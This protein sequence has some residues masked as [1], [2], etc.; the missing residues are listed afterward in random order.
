MNRCI[1]LLLFA[2][3][4]GTS[5]AG[6]EAQI[7]VEEPPHY[8]GEPVTVRIVVRGFEE[9]PQPT[10]EIAD[11]ASSGLR[12]QL[13]ALQPSVS[14]SLQIVQDSTG[15]PQRTE[16]KTV[17]WLIDHSATASKPGEYNVGPFVVRQGGREVRVEAIRLTF[18]DVAIDPDM[19]VQLT[20]PEKPVYPD[21]RVPVTVAWSY[22]GEL[23]QIN[24]LRI[25][26]PLFD[27][28]R[29][30]PEE[31]QARR[32]AV[33]LPIETKEG[34]VLLAAAARREADAGKTFTVL[35]AERTLIPDR[36][37]TFELEPITATVRKVTRWERSRS[38]FDDLGFGGSMFGDLLGEGRRPAKTELTRAAG[39]GQTLVVKPFPTEGRPGQFCRR[40]R[41]GLFPRRRGGA[42]RR[43][44]GRSDHALA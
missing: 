3:C 34:Q 23:E 29:F 41:A 17:V 12:M 42:N 2:L 43:A 21:Q 36:V 27:Q 26:S 15:R 31:K 25:Y 19:R 13:A 18:D 10:V 38:P 16:R 44:R 7:A 35:S 5:V 24:Q 20:L 6:Q 39:E 32:D 4:W 30:A 11:A 40:G 14:R 1:L 28:F 33:E 22:A 37:G 8:V 9:S